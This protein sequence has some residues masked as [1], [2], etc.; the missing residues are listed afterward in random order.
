MMISRTWLYVVAIAAASALLEVLAVFLWPITIDPHR[1]WLLP[2]LA[3]F[4]AVAGRF[5]FKVSPQGDATLITVPLFMA[6]LSLHPVEAALVGATG[7][8]V[9]EVLLKAPPKVAGFNLSVSS[10][11]AAAGGIVFWSFQGGPGATLFT[12]E[13]VVAAVAA[14]L[15]VHVADISL[16]FGMITLVKGHNF[17]QRWR[18]VWLFESVLASSLLILGLI[19]AQLMYFAWWWLFLLATPFAVAY[20]GFRRSVE[21]ITQKTNLAN[22]LDSRLTELKETQSQLIQSAKLA[23]VG[24]M[25]AGVG[26]EINNPLT[27]ISGRAQLLLMRLQN[28]QKPFNQEKTVKDVEEINNMALRISTIV[29]QLL[30][31]SRKAD[32]F[33]N[34]ALD[35]VMDDAVELLDAKVKKKGITVVREYQPAA[36]VRGV[37]NQLQQVFVNLVGNAI[38]AMPSWGEITLGYEGRG[39]MVVAYVK[40]TGIGISEEAM[41]TIFEPFFTT[42]EVGKGTGLGLFIC[43]KIII[44]H[45]GEITVDSVPGE[46]TTFIIKL[47]VAEAEPNEDN[48]IE[49]AMDSVSAD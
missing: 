28:P 32:T 39:D 34:V 14:G 23:T 46:G 16:L 35:L 26:H 37:S 25:A 38:D 36:H 2:T 45:G 4:V 33:E 49:E 17:L 27:V 20:Y 3:F 5:P 8:L 21:E 1:L 41:K 40:D 11:V 7:T 22:E 24:T 9:S 19:G 42:K 6:V 47:P 10:T 29:N 18:E 43:Q 31:Y 15:V 44:D 48:Q 12:P 30:A 13:T